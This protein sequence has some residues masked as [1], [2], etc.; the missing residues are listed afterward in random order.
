MSNIKKRKVLGLDLGSN[1]IGWALLEDVEK[2]PQSIIDLGCRIFN[3][4]VEDK[5]PTPK[6]VSRRNARLTRR[7]LQRRSRRKRRMLHY[8]IS[9]G[10]LPESLKNDH[11]PEITLNSIGDPYELRAKALDDPLENYEMGRGFLHFVQRRGFLSNRKT[12]LG[13]LVDDPDVMAVLAEAEEE[14]DTSSE[15]AKE[16]TLFKKQISVL[17]QT[18]TD[19][20]CRTLGEYLAT[21]EAPQTR[22]NRTHAGG[23]LRTDRQ[24]YREELD[25]IW[26]KQSE[27]LSMLTE[28]VKEQIEEIIFFQRPLKLRSDRIGKCSLEPKKNR[29]SIAR[30]ECQRFRYLQDI[31]NLQYMLPDENE[32]TK[33]DDKQ[34]EKLVD[35]FESKGSISFTEVKKTLD[36]KRNVKINIE[37]GGNKKLKG[38]ITATSIRKVYPGWDDLNGSQQ[39]DLVEDLL[40]TQKKSTLKKRLTGHWKLPAEIAVELCMMEFEPGHSN[41]SLNAIKKLMPHLENGMIFSDA[42]VAAGYGYE[43]QETEEQE[44]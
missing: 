16:E 21:I 14:E 38:N 3:K 10:L 30:L 7:V 26:K 17:R 6:N 29:A 32:W 2:R 39:L 41:L 18:I 23:E 42:R 43:V 33:L 1:S 11:S 9:L 35:L 8:M 34:R 13:D 36:L 28:D 20:K 12:I 24:M 27:H 37:E 40:T 25:L 15:Q 5:T 19:K 31:S 4:A 22:R 44:R